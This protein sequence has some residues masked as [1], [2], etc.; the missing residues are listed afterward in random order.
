M[1]TSL[2]TVVQTHA[3][4]EGGGS[5]ECKGHGNLGKHPSIP[6]PF[7]LSLWKRF[8]TRQ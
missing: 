1:Y 6:R 8:M 7:L 5:L 3:E 2:G 4:S